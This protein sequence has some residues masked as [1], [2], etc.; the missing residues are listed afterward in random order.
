MQPRLLLLTIIF[1]LVAGA[2]HAAGG[3]QLQSRSVHGVTILIDFDSPWEGAYDPADLDDLM[4]LPGYDGF[5][6]NGSVRDYFL[7]VSGGLFDYT[8]EVTTEYFRAPHPRSYYQDGDVYDMRALVIEAL[9]WFDQQ[10]FDFTQFDSD[11]DNVIDAINVLCFGTGI[12]GGLRP[13]T[14]SELDITLDGYQADRYQ[15][16]DLRLGGSGPVNPGLTTIV[17]ENGHM[18]FDWPDVYP[19]EDSSVGDLG[20]FCIM[21]NVYGGYKDP[22]EPNAFYKWKAGWIVLNQFDGEFANGFLSD[23]V[24]QAAII[25]HPDY[26]LNQECYILENRQATGRD[27][28]LPASGIA[29]YHVA[30]ATDVQ[31]EITLFEADGGNEVRDGVNNGEPSDLWHAPHRAAFDYA[32]SPALVWDD[33]TMVNFHME[34]ISTNAS[35]MSY[36]YDYYDYAD[37]QITA[38]PVNLDATWELTCGGTYQ[39]SGQGDAQVRVIAGQSCTVTFQDF[40]LWTTPAPITKT[41]PAGLGYPVPFQTAYAG[42][43][44]PLAGS[45]LV[46]SQDATS[47]TMIDIDADGDDDMFV[48][49]EGGTNRLL[50]NDGFYF[51]DIAPSVLANAGNTEMA[52]WADVDNDGDLDVFLA[53]ST[54]ANKLLHQTSQSPLT[55]VDVTSQIAESASIGAVS[56]ASWSDVDQDGVL[57]LFL[58]RFSD[59]NLLYMGGNQTYTAASLLGFVSG[60]GATVGARWGDYDADGYSDLF[61]GAS[62]GNHTS[63]RVVHNAAGVLSYAGSHNVQTGV[64]DPELTDAKWA[65]INNDG[66]VDLVTLNNS[67]DGTNI[68]IRLQELSE[69]N[70]KFVFHHTQFSAQDVSAF[71]VGDFDNDGWIDIFIDREGTQDLLALNDAEV[72]IEGLIH[73]TSIPLAYDPHEGPAFAV[74]S[75]DVNN[76]GG[77][78]LFL[79]KGGAADVLVLNFL[80]SRGNWLAVDLEGT[81]ANRDA[82]GATVYVTTGTMT[83]VREVGAGGGPGQG[84]HVLHFGLGEATQADVVRVVWDGSGQDTYLGA[85]AANQRLSVTQGASRAMPVAAPTEETPR[86]TTALHGASPNPFNPRTEISFTLATDSKVR[87]AIYSVRGRKVADLLNDHLRAGPHSL[88]WSGEDSSGQRVASGTYLFR[89]FAGRDEFTSKLVLIK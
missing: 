85:V 66:M 31:S 5:G 69:G 62:D 77:L 52:A 26:P 89:M 55:F 72:D 10:G 78:D 53:S 37:I 84:S 8:N 64:G 42:S 4:N 71:E 49:N 68:E 51:V 57:D 74:A 88:I 40:P 32:S 25:R 6:I 18:L 50:R 65:D 7:D 35:V 17:H 83:Q 28:S 60:G 23:E 27:S 33:G 38:L 16:S 67:G 12:L 22:V 2:A 21:G 13:R 14:S 43:F 30:D 82:V 47:V 36:T 20:A 9:Q 15:V 34:N 3:G 41:V 81:S 19:G 59:T 39:L 29:I 44:L 86:Y 75:L 61:M 45:G 46:D 79:G 11:G 76:D 56:S 80:A 1:T 73:F 70:L 58:A 87:A 54:G 63:P 24:N 48:A